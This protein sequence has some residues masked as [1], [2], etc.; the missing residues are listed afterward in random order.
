M[1]LVIGDSC[2][3]CSGEMSDIGLLNRSD[4]AVW[5]GKTGVIEIQLPERCLV[6]ENQHNRTILTEVG[7]YEFSADMKI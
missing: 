3:I 6:I 1:I 5:S 4:N 7:T 2:S